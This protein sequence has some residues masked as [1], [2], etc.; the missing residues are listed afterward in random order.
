MEPMTPA[1]IEE[2]LR[3]FRRI[4]IALCV[5]EGL[6]LLLLM[7]IINRGGWFVFFSGFLLVLFVI[8]FL[9][10]CFY[11]LVLRFS[12]SATF[13]QDPFKKIMMSSWHWTSGQPLLPEVEKT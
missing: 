8:L 11:L 5:I 3:Q 6:V 10:V 2:T 13:T 7:N 12:R 1:E 9:L 4:A